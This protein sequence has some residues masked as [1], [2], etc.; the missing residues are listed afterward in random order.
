[1]AAPDLT[2]LLQLDPETAVSRKTNEP[3][4]YVRARAQITANTD[5]SQ[6]GA[7]IIDAAQPL[8]QVVSRL[9]AELWSSL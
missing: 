3:A 9:K 5:W 7:R 1:M 6:S 2:F 4:D 8:P